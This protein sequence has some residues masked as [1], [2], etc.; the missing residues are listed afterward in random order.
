VTR[1]FTETRA[2]NIVLLEMIFTATTSATTMGT[3]SAKRDGQGNTVTKLSTRLAATLGKDRAT[4]LDSAS[5]R[6]VWKDLTV[7]IAGRS[8]AANME[9]AVYPGSATVCLD[10][11]ES[12]AIKKSATEDRPS[13][14]SNAYAS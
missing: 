2:P 14:S 9:P 11:E 13:D 7:P 4:S 12:I 5:V 6:W 1:I 3:R 10:G 8:Q